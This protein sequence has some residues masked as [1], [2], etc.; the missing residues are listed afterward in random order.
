MFGIEKDFQKLMEQV[1]GPLGEKKQMTE[2]TNEPSGWN[3]VFEFPLDER[4][5]II[6][7]GVKYKRVETPQSFYD[8]LWGLLSTK[9]SDNVYACDDMADKVRDLI[10]EH[11]PEPKKGPGLPEYYVGYNDAI[12]E[13]NLRLFNGIQ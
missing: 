12:R 2:K 5:T 1:Y 6:I 4:D 10:R 11:I 3:P 13:V 8:K 9:I 7:D